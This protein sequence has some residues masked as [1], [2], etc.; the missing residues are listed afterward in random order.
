MSDRKKII[1]VDDEIRVL[2]GLRRML[3][4]M[5]NQW[6]MVFAGSGEEALRELD[7][8][9]YDVIVSDMRM[10]G[11]HGADLLEIVKRKYPQMV[12]IALS[13]QSSK[14]EVLRT[15]G[16]VH[17]YLPKPC[18]AE[19]LKTTITHVCSFQKVLANPKLQALVAQLES[20][21]CISS[22]YSELIEELHSEDASIQ[23]VSGIILQDVGMTV[24]I[25]QMVN[26]AFFGVRQHV[27]NLSQAVILLG[28]ETI[29]TLAISAK[30]FS[31]FET[32]H[33]KQFSIHSLWRH[34]MEVGEHA[35][36]IAQIEQVDSIIVD[37]ALLSGMLHD[38]GKLIFAT[39]LPDEYDQTIAAAQQENISLF[40]AER[41]RI[42]ATHAEVGAYLLGLWGFKTPIIETLLFHHN[43]QESPYKAF[44]VLTAVCIANLFSHENSPGPASQTMKPCIGHLEELGLSDRL[45]VWREACL[46]KSKITC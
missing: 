40:E 16:P 38:V 10:P 39:K 21:P 20:L 3:R 26:S 1:F 13:G 31:C 27:Q 24:K 8:K 18:D 6:D 11:M 28:L 37:Y 34:C 17:Q 12:R 14:A 46:G 32:A 29:R 23:K 36:H 44:S 7:S 30:I 45:P 4:V 41:Q 33:L 15:V 25:L 22:F 2:E 9:A 43:P 35:K 42:G 19:T 5:R